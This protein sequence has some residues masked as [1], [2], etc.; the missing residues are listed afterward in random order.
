MSMGQAERLVDVGAV[1][2]RGSFSKRTVFRLN[3]AG[4]LPAPVRV[5]GCLRWR[6][7][8]IEAWMAMGCPDRKTFETRKEAVV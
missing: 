7:S 6:E 5:G 1:A 3:S 2:E 4:K 8:D